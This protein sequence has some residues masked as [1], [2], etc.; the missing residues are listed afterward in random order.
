MGPLDILNPFTI[1]LMVV[2]IAGIGFAGYVATR[3]LGP[4]RGLAVTALLGGL[5]SSTAVTLSFSGRARNNAEGVPAAASAILL[6]SA[7]MFGRMIVEVAVVHAP[8]LARLSLPLGA[9]IVACVGASYWTYARA[10]TSA[11]VPPAVPLKNPFELGTALRFGLVFAG[12]IFASRAA[13]LHAGDAGL[14]ATAALAGTTDVDAITLSTANLAHGG[15]DAR[16]AVTAILIGAASNTLVKVG[17][18]AVLGGRKLGLLVASGGAVALVC[19][20]LGALATW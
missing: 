10:R 15:M 14:F 2:L 19:G 13:S 12:V 11:G 6:A 8:L 1:G 18:A 9:S 7:I 20:A 17:L 3:L 5:V 16:V 4:G